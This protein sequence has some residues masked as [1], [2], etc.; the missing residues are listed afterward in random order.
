M[1]IQHI[2]LFYTL[3]KYVHMYKL[4]SITRIQGRLCKDWQGHRSVEEKIKKS[5]KRDSLLANETLCQVEV[6]KL[7]AGLQR[8]EEIV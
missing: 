4:S 1:V 5:L 3:S 2:R 7:R 6:K 8:F